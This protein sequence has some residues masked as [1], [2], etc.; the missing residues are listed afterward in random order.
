V[1]VARTVGPAF[2][3]RLRWTWVAPMVAFVLVAWTAWREVARR[4]P[5]A[6]RRVLVP[7]AL[8]SLVALSGVHVATGARG[9]TP[10]EPDSAVVATLLPDLL[11]AVEPGEGQV[12]VHDPY[13]GAAYYTR[14]MVLEMERRGIDARVPPERGVLF[15]ERRVVDED[16]P[17]QARLVVVQNSGVDVLAAK[18]EMELVVEWE[19]PGLDEAERAAAERDEIVE[20]LDPEELADPE[21]IEAL[22]RLEGLDNPNDAIADRV[23]IYLDHG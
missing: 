12:V 17:I 19:W 7:L 22:G 8:A 18:P 5:W 6:E 2:D 4:W 10:R 13:H 20:G 23:A 15:G 21:I 9:V 1:A 16:E 11:A 3:Y 14:A